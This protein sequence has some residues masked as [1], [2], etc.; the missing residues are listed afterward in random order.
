MADLIVITYRRSVFGL[1]VR[2]FSDNP[3]QCVHSKTIIFNSNRN[4][5]TVPCV[6][7]HRMSTLT[8]QLTVVRQPSYIPTEFIYSLYEYE[9]FIE[10]DALCSA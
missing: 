7:L 4:V 2:D 5:N 1:Q 10:R 8:K 6:T 3:L 9:H